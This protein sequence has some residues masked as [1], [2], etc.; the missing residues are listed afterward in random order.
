MQAFVSQ[1]HAAAVVKEY[2]CFWNDTESKGGEW[3]GK[4]MVI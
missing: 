4:N 1:A 2:I 3:P